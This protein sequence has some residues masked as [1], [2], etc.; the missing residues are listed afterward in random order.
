MESGLSSAPEMHLAGSRKAFDACVDTV[1]DQIQQANVALAKSKIGHPISSNA[2]GSRYKQ[3]WHVLVIYAFP[4]ELDRQIIDKLV[5]LADAVKGGHGAL[6][7]SYED[8]FGR[9][10]EEYERKLLSRLEPLVGRD[11][12]WELSPIQP[13]SDSDIGKAI[14]EGCGHLSHQG[15]EARERDA[16]SGIDAIFKMDYSRSSAEGLEF[17][18]GV[19][20]GG[21]LTRLRFDF[22]LANNSAVLIG[23][24]GSG[25]TNLLH[26]LILNGVLHYS[27][28][29]LQLYL[30]D[31]KEGL[32]FH[33]YAKNRLPH[34]AVV[35]LG[36]DRDFVLNCL[37]EIES[38]FRRRADAFASQLLLA[39]RWTRIGL[40]AAL[41][42]RLPSF[43]I[44]S[45][46]VT[47]SSTCR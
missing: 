2:I 16:R 42:L 32:D 30:F 44:K 20:D 6:L 4:T 24:P 25:K 1:L 5:I 21:R 47:P 15:E 7:V 34:A 8:D 26:V 12:I 37:R 33:P 23:Q 9:P 36:S 10:L 46:S 45:S 22:D 19:D 3:R 28:L 29:E 13:Q 41:R 35:S 40:M 11:G 39:G 17:E 38:K 14:A 43:L 18:V 27:P 31:F